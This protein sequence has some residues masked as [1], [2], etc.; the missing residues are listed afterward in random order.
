MT[1]LEFEKILGN[2]V[3]QEEYDEIEMVY[4]FHPV[5]SNTDGKNEI[6]ALYKLGVISDLVARAEWAK[7]IDSEIN[8]VKG[9]IARHQ[10]TLRLLYEQLRK[11]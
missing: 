6:V 2:E 7:E 10:E 9:I 11:A 5:I 4:N 3:T 1:K 8:R